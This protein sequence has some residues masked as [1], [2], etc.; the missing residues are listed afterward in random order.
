[1]G[2]HQQS[3]LENDGEV[4]RKAKQRL[5]FTIY[6]LDK[7]LSLRLGRP[8][9]IPEYNISLSYEPTEVRWNKAANVQARV[10][11]ELYSSLG[12]SRS[13]A[14]RI[15]SVTSLS[16]ELR[17]LIDVRSTEPDNTSCGLAPNIYSQSYE[18][19]VNPLSTDVMLKFHL[20]AEQVEMLSVLTLV[21]R[22]VFSH[23]C[24][25]SSDCSTAAREAMDVHQYTI[26]SLQASTNEP[27][28]T[29]RY[30]NR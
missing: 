19:A 18:Y 26:A 22:A 11:D 27:T 6:R 20:A 15:N 29:A 21:H 30:I 8:S 28:A 23:D 1:L 5:F 3:F 14:D 12:L 9:N 24:G 13:D 10:Y 17:M 16:G 4:V 2:F 7:S 25:I